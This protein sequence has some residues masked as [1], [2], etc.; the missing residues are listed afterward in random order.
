MSGCELRESG[1]A[2]LASSLRTDGALSLNDVPMLLKVMRETFG[3]SL[4][5][6][7]GRAPGSAEPEPP[8]F[9]TAEAKVLL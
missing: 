7:R 3:L 2:L 9:S 6:H 4:Q 1:A 8:S 5:S